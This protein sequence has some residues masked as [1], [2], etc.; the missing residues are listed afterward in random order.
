MDLT[1]ISCELHNFVKK[2]TI[3]LLELIFKNEEL[4]QVYPGL[5]EKKNNI[6]EKYFKQEKIKINQCKDTKNKIDKNQ[7]I[8]LLR[9]KKQCSNKKNKTTNYCTRH[10]KIRKFGEISL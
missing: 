3:E 1:D 9:N 10:S 7:C 2:E 5:Y 6:I 4:N 8:A